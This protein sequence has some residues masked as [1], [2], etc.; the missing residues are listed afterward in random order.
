MKVNGP[1]VH[2]DG[3]AMIP[4]RWCVERTRA[5]ITAHRPLARDYERLPA[6]SE[7]LIR[8]AF[9]AGALNRLDSGHP[10]VRQPR[11][12]WLRHPRLTPMSNTH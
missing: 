6:T 11:W 10:A 8:W 7:G 2:L 12:R 3:F 4:R 1:L 5:W 9:I